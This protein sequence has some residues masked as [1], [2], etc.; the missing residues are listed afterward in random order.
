MHGSLAKPGSLWQYVFSWYTGIHY[1]CKIM[2]RL[3]ACTFSALGSFV[4]STLARE[5]PATTRKSGAK[6]HKSC[7]ES[8]H[9]ELQ[10]VPVL[11]AL[12]QPAGAHYLLHFG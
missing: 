1:F 7:C 12:F 6:H 3:F 5:E 11:D 4:H 2:H 10:V 8:Q 9:V